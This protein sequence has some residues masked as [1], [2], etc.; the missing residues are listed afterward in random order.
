M[1]Q[2][3]G[4]SMFSFFK[5]KNQKLVKQW[6]KE[7]VQIVAL[8]GKI[9]AAYTDNDAKATRK[10][11][12]ALKRL[13]LNHL[14]TEDIELYNMLKEGELIDIDTQ[15]LTK[16]FTESF[17]GTKL[18]LMKFLNVYSQEDIK[19]DETFFEAF[20]GIVAV[21]GERIAFEEDNLYVGLDSK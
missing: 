7:H 15:R 4:V 18:A 14:M 11:L 2:L 1:A 12:L 9:I 13:A 20:N 19:F 3:L 17:R 10:E 5:S 16:E 6:K 21:L 8:A